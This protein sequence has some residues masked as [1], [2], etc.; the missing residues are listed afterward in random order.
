MGETAGGGGEKEGQAGN[1][2][3]FRYST[4]STEDLDLALLPP[5]DPHW[6]SLLAKSKWKAQV[7][8]AQW[9]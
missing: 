9:M 6:G 4:L 8:V 5:C 3:T 1:R 7:T 2:V